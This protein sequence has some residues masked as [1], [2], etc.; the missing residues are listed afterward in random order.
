MSININDLTHEYKEQNLAIIEKYIKNTDYSDAIKLA[1]LSKLQES[2]F[3]VTGIYELLLGSIKTLGTLDDYKFR[4]DKLEN[5]YDD[6]DSAYFDLN[7]RLKGI[8]TELG[9]EFDNRLNKLKQTIIEKDSQFLQTNEKI[10]SE[11]KSIEMSGKLS[12]RLISL[13]NRISELSIQADI[14][15]KTLEAIASDGKLSYEEKLIVNPIWLKIRS[16][17]SS[18][19]YNINQYEIDTSPYELAYDELREYVI[20]LQMGNARETIID[21]VLFLS[22]FKNY[23][24]ERYKAL[25]EV[26]NKIQTETLDKTNNFIDS[27]L[28]VATLNSLSFKA[29]SNNMDVIRLFEDG[30]KDGHLTPIEKERIKDYYDNI[31][32]Q[33]ELDKEMAIKYNVSYQTLEG[34]YDKLNS[35]IQATEIFR[36]ME[37]HISIDKD[38]FIKYFTDF[39]EAQ[40]ELYQTL[41]LKCKEK[42][43]TFSEDVRYYATRIDQTDKRLSLTAESIEAVGKMIEVNRAYIDMMANGIRLGT[44]STTIPKDI[45][46]ALD[47][48]NSPGENL[49]IVGKSK[50]GY[51]SIASGSL[52][53]DSINGSRYSDFIKVPNSIMCTLSIEENTVDNNL[54]IVWYDEARK[55][56]KTDQ[57]RSS[58]PEITFTVTSPEEAFFCRIEVLNARHCLIKFEIGANKT[59][60]KLSNYDLMNNVVLAKEVVDAKSRSF[61]EFEKAL[62]NFNNKNYQQLINALLLDDNLTVSDKNLLESYTDEILTF[63]DLLISHM[64]ELHIDREQLDVFYREFMSDVYNVSY[65]K[66][67]TTNIAG[68]NMNNKFKRYLDELLINASHTKDELDKTRQGSLDDWNKSTASA[69]EA[70]VI[71]QELLVKSESY[72]RAISNFKRLLRQET[73]Y[74][75]EVEENLLEVSEDNVITATEKVPINEYISKV[76]TSDEWFERHA[77]LYNVGKAEFIRTK[78]NLIDYINPML[79]IV[80]LNEDTIVSSEIFMNRFISYFRAKEDLLMNIISAAEADYEILQNEVEMAI[81]L[82]RAKNEELINYQNAITEATKDINI[83]HDNI[84]ELRDAVPYTIKLISS[85]GDKF[86]NGNVNTTLTCTIFRGNID[87]TNQIKSEHFIWTK[88]DKDGEDDLTWNSN[89]ENV[90]N[91][92]YID[93]NDISEKAIFKVEVFQEIGTVQSQT[94][95]IENNK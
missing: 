37:E 49:Y 77:D 83:I 8:S 59:E 13:Y 90:G 95:T 63:H 22:K 21:N 87:I 60:F 35:L 52:F 84:N 25:I 15:L 33:F 71:K 68:L 78:N 36:F 91:E 14:D 92:I 74:H 38:I 67:S 66:Y 30:M 24:D 5:P 42:I 76:K 69:A 16:E 48:L 57:K 62:I 94:T 23:Y 12:D 11:V 40:L 65:D 31:H 73:L 7:N 27:S 56:I 58:E 45:S 86:T 26:Y 20:T 93:H 89:H 72:A 51:I 70:E 2:D 17:K 61:I 47:E 64:D 85:H 80:S 32:Y 1:A 10:L 41:L 43:N 19:V 79:T 29:R 53:N 82:A 9:T 18:L 28:T 39:Y 44:E 34:N 55:Y 88:R 6:P 50:P 4:I 75:Y 81:A 54:K 3:Y 46:N